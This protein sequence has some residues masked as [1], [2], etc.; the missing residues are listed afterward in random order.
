MAKI[1]EY[2]NTLGEDC[3]LI[4]NEDGT[5]VS[6][7]KAYYEELEAAQKNVTKQSKRLGGFQS[8][9]RDRH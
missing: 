2:Q 6:M 5:T 4:D 3:L 7:T 8:Q 1:T 9:S